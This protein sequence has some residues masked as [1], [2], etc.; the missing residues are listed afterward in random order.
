ML[1]LAR[2]SGTSVEIE[3]PGIENTRITV[4]VVS[5]NG[6][7]VKLGFEAPS[8]YRILRQE[9]RIADDNMRRAIGH[10]T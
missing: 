9:L 3:V 2:K 10:E 8:A 6:G 4:R 1:V 7:Q 5:V